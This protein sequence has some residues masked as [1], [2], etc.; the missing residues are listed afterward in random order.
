ML[1]RMVA[2]G[3]CLAI[4]TTAQAG[5]T[6]GIELLPE[7]PAPYSPGESLDVEVRLSQIGGQE[8][9]VRLVTFD[10]SASNPGIELDAWEWDYSEGQ[11]VC[12]IVPEVCGGGWVEFGVLP[13]VNTTFAGASPDPNLSIFLP[14]GGSIL[15]GTLGITLPSELGVGVTLEALNLPNDNP[16]DGARVDVGVDPPMTIR[17]FEGGSFTFIPEPATLTLLVIGAAA[18]A[19]RR[20]RRRVSIDSKGRRS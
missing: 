15:L 4:A 6:L 11:P 1:H 18:A 20:T 9:V 5:V 2:V 12:T 14:V 13:E 10:F 8:E 19:A 17:E 3:V 16:G 7:H